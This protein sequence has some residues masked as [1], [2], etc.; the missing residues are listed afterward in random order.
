MFSKNINMSPQTVGGGSDIGSSFSA[1]L[2]FN[3]ETMAL[4]YLELRC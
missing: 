4:V 1:L 2:V 3:D